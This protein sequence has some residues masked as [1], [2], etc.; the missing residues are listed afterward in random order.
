M[1]AGMWVRSSLAYR[2]SF[3]MLV[4]GNLTVTTMD[5]AV[6]VI[7]FQ[8]TGRLGGWDLPQVAFLYGTSGFAIGT[9]DLLVGSIDRLGERIRLGTLDTMLVR[10]APA[11]AQMAADRFGLRRLGRPLQ[12]TAILAWSLTAVQ[13][14][15]TWDRVLL[16]PVLLISGTAIFV[17]L[18]V[19][20]A[21]FQ[22][23]AADAAEAQNA[24]TYGGA[25]MLQYP[26][27]VFGRD[28]LA[29]AVFGVP[30]AFVNWLPALHI[31]GRPDPLGL[32]EAFRFASPVAAALALAVAGLAWRT[33]LRTYR[34]TGS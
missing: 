3:A 12:A 23:W 16:V 11:L 5:F 21:S 25:T 32:P 22:F 19:G 29:G 14:H 4:L 33:G 26:P 7:M 10:P 20:G 31:L 28:L 24:F 9:A 17:A 6:I 13:V 15:W 8:H 2:A 30:L 1:S 27:A 34:S 18:F